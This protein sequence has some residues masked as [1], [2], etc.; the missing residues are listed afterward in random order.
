MI[1]RVQ[2]LFL[3]VAAVCFGAACF[4]A[5][6]TVNV[7]GMGIGISYAYSPWVTIICKKIFETYYIG[8]LQVILAMI[9]FVAIFF[10]KNRPLQS[11]ICTAAIFIG[12]LLLLLMLYVYP[13]RIF[14]NAIGIQG[15]E[16][17]YSL[18][19]FLSILPV[20]LLY[21]ANKFILKDE[22]KVRAAD[23]LR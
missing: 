20:G 3:L 17:K 2:S 14:P 5:I 19:A 7:E 9:S 6:G 18:W 21:L 22:K 4:V 11:K 12:F 13:D 16:V 8:L 23:R 15:V 1:Q 10:Y